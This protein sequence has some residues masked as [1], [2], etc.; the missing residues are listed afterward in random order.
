M[1]PLSRLP[2]R[3]LYATLFAALAA[4][5]ARSQE[6]P[7]AR[8]A[9]LSFVEGS[10]KLEPANLSEWVLASVNTPIEQGYKL[11]TTKNSFA[12]VQFE[13]GSTVRAGES[14]EVDFRRLSAD[15]AGEP[16]NEVAL[17]RGYAT[18]HG[19]SET[20]GAYRVRVADATINAPEPAEFRVDLDQGAVRV[21]VFKGSVAYSAPQ[22]SAQL[23]ANG[24]LIDEPGSGKPYSISTGITTDG[25]DAWVEARDSDQTAVQD[26]VVT[27][28]SYSSSTGSDLYGWSDLSDY[29]SWV[30]FAG[31]GY[32]WCPVVS[33]GWSPYTY[34]RWAW[35]PGLGY[36]WISY[37]P[38]GWL[39]FHYGRWGYMP[40]GFGWAWIPGGFQTWSPAT[41][42]WYQGTGWIGW[43]PR[44]V[45]GGFPQTGCGQAGG[46]ITAMGVQAFQS[47]LPVSSE[48]VRIIS[49]ERA[50][51]VP[52]PTVRPARLAMLPGRPLGS[53]VSGA[54]RP[55]R[56][57]AAQDEIADQAN[58]HRAAMIHGG[59]SPALNS[60]RRASAFP[61]VSKPFV[62]SITEPSPL[63]H[64]GVWTPRAA[65]LATTHFSL[66]P[67]FILGGAHHSFGAASSPLGIHAGT[68]PSTPHVANPRVS[69]A[70][71]PLG[72]GGHIGPM[73][74]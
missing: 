42:N 58:M 45:N 28:E 72:G 39:P 44:L 17:A 50:H 1:K 34:G 3:I 9:R 52:N 23:D 74:R 14:S 67:D 15:S 16:V 38:W 27:P 40:N 20:G 53:A 49:A 56:G 10:V 7:A 55:P 22:G 63:L 60:W 24:V 13:D 70:V 48:Y 4:G 21:E 29:G 47:G 43:M 37:E 32:G 65:P 46:C 73:G 6:N 62:P 30:Y 57:P 69:G 8:V 12:E 54:A 36:T 64:P 19:L 59:A 31:Y 2:F 61:P 35:Y 33:Y 25:W 26:Q 18:F 41:V 66:V 51:S 11:A 71:G 68:P 5:A